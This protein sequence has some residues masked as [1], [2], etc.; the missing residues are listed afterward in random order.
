MRWALNWATALREK[1]QADVEI[2]FATTAISR[3]SR[4]LPPVRIP[5]LPVLPHLC[6]RSVTRG[7]ALLV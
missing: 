5:L 4:I 2:R 3:F 7:A 6:N 1:A